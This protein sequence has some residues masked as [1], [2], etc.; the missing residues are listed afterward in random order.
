MNKGTVVVSTA[1]KDRSLVMAVW[2]VEDGF[3][4]VVNGR[5]HRLEHPKRK[6]P[7]HL[8]VS[9]LSVTESDMET[10]RTLRRALAQVTASLND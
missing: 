6:N 2:S 8:R 9:G 3:V 7:R 1:G 5:E 4:Y 10:N